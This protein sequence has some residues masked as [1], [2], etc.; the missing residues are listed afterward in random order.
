MRGRINVLAPGKYGDELVAWSDLLIP[1]FD[2][3]VA[4]FKRLDDEDLKTFWLNVAHATSAD[5][6]GQTDTFSGWITAFA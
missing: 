4:T 3:F 5:M 2:R 6:S 1:I